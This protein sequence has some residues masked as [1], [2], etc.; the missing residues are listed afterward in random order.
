MDMES[1]WLGWWCVLGVK[2]ACG[3]QQAKGCVSFSHRIL[4]DYRVH[5]KHTDGSFEYVPY[6]SLPANDL[7]DVIG[8]PV[9]LRCRCTSTSSCSCTV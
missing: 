9:E 5:I 4:Q 6:F 8:E 2:A 7:N 3:W 1:A